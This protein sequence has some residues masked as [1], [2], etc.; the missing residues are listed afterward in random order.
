[1]IFDCTYFFLHKNFHFDQSIQTLS[2]KKKILAQME[3]EVIYRR[4][5]F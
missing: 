4:S 5:D 1:M 3:H 2:D